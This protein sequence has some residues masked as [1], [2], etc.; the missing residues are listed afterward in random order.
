MRMWVIKISAGKCHKMFSSRW[1]NKHHHHHHHHLLLVIIVLSAKVV[2]MS[3]FL[4]LC[5]CSHSLFT[6]HVNKSY[7]RMHRFMVE[8]LECLLSLS[9]NQNLLPSL[10]ETC[11]LRLRLFQSL[12]SL[13][14]SSL[15]FKFMP[16]HVWEM[17]NIQN[18]EIIHEYLSNLIEKQMNDKFIFRLKF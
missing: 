10:C 16:Q 9:A 18:H 5:L 11:R 7:M 13:L 3:Q 8:L 2:K 14:L 15:G 12:H 17:S 1:T 6:P 4:L